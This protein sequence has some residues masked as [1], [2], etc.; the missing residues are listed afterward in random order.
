MKHSHIRYLSALL[1]I[2]LYF[3]SCDDNKK[4][5]NEAETQATEVKKINIPAFNQDSAYQFIADQVGFGPRVPNSKA[6]QLTGDYIIRKLEDYGAEITVQ[7]FEATAYDG[8]HLYL[9]NIIGSINPTAKKRIILAAH[10]DTRPFADKDRNNK[11]KPIDGAND[12][13]SGVA[14][15]LEIARS[16]NLSKEKPDVGI[17]FIF[18]DGED[19]GPH[20]DYKGNLAKE[21]ENYWC[22]GSQYWAKNK[23]QN[24]YSAYYGILLDMV[25]AKN[26][27][28]Y[29]ES[30]SMHYAPSIV[31]KVW[32]KANQIGHGHFFKNKDSGIVTDDHYFVNKIAKIPMIDII[33]YDEELFFGAYHHTH[34]DNMNIIDKSTLNA[35]G[36]TLLHVLYN[37]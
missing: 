20:V 25:G 37:E 6:H 21:D 34:D 11:V 8:N 7:E 15:I 35:V 23:H 29:R 24:G 10:W 36:E 22:L 14:V 2:L 3:T 33:D 27:K 5:D 26:A 30:Y 16:I 13:G 9:K 17:D 4:G 1:F 19:Y 12:G 31:K 32:D 28:F 18:F